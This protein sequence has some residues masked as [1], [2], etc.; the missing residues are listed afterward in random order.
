MPETLEIVD[1]YFKID[2]PEAPDGVEK[3]KS[4]LQFRAKCLGIELPA[5]IEDIDKVEALISSTARNWFTM[6]RLLKVLLRQIDCQ[7]NY[8]ETFCNCRK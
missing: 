4:D 3:E 7:R 6:R 5:E 8:F 1:T 2:L